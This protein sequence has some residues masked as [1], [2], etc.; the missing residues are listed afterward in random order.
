MS[1]RPVTIAVALAMFIG[2][3]A[4]VFRVANPNIKGQAAISG[5][6]AG[7]LGD[8]YPRWYGTRQLLLYGQNPY[9]QQ[10]SDDLQR[11]Y[12]GNVQSNG[13]R[14]EQRF[15]YPIFVSLFLLPTVNL[16]FSR[17]QIIAS[18]VM[19]ATLAISIPLWLGFI[20]WQ[21][22]RWK[23]AVLMLL[24][25]SCS[26]AVQALEMQQISTLVCALI[27][28]GAFLLRRR[29]YVS[30][31]MFFALAT[32]KPQ[33]V[34]L[35]YL[36]LLL[37]TLSKWRE[38]K[39][40]LLSFSV[41]IVILTLIGQ[42]MVPGWVGQFISAMRAYRRYAGDSAQS[43][44]EMSFGHALGDVLIFAILLALAIACFRRRKE[45][46]DSSRFSHAAAV[47]LAISTVVLPPA[48][49]YNHLLLLPGVL[50]LLSGWS[51]LW[52]SGKLVAGISALVTA[53]AL[54]PWIAAIG[55]LLVS[56][57]SPVENWALPF[58]SSLVVPMSV[59]ALLVL[60]HKH[61]PILSHSD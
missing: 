58:Y 36:W 53:A 22:A 29:S 6:H 24:V 45:S 59:A 41:G 11:S 56:F 7:D 17:V 50:V 47:V 14:D 54:W 43:I 2:M 31:G 39:K 18:L 60:P 27:A 25:L 23:V 32:I 30:S 21:L 35:L 28:T 34:F 38:R 40:L 46:A 5:D 15:A 33:M 44:I 8:L 12:Y 57:F 4:Y 26:P 10:V 52:R 49:P 1:N 55:L 3:W 42:W 13:S 20:G 9:G 16:E 37:W 51:N 19:A 61:S 48:A